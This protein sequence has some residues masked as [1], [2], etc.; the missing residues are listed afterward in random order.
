M[1]EFFATHFGWLTDVSLVTLQ[2]ASGIASAMFLFLVASG[3]SL[4]F[5][6]SRIINFAHGSFY[7]FGAYFAHTWVQL[8][9]GTP[10]EFWVMLILASLSVALLGGVLEVLFLRRIY[11]AD[12][13]FQLLLTFAFVLLLSDVAKILWGAEGKVVPRPEALAG[14]VSILGTPFPR[15]MLLVVAAGF[16]VGLAL[17]VVFYRTRWGRL[18]RAARH[19]RDML[20]ALGTNV[21]RLFTQ[22][23]MLGSALAGLAGAMVAP[24][25]TAAPGMDASIIIDAFVVVVIG[26]LGSFLGAALASLLVAVLKALG[27]V[28]FPAIS[29]VLAYVVMAVVLIFRPWGLF[30]RREE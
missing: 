2:L 17:W 22:V 12:P 27:T 26:G 4:I 13:I 21:P 15:Y 30:G 29:M 20:G 28:S 9:G 1:L 19:S 23:F 25:V 14:S 11:H 10:G 16:L 7:M 18:V 6:V 3:L 24:I 5:G 8:L